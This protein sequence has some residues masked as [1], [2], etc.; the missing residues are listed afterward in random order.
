MVTYAM[1]LLAH[2]LLIGMLENNPT[3]Y[4]YHSS[5]TVVMFC[6]LT[7]NDA[8]LYADLLTDSAA[9]TIGYTSAS[10]LAS[11]FLAY[12]WIYFAMGHLMTTCIAVYYYVNCFGM[13]LHTLVPSFL[14][15]SFAC[16][17]IA[18]YTELLDKKE[19]LE[20]ERIK[21][22]K[23][24]LNKVLKSMPE[25]VMIFERYNIDKIKLWN[26]SFLNLFGNL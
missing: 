11:F 14:M 8:S 9:I 18:Y 26:D 5:L 17:S 13:M 15:S 2:Y 20:K 10:Y 21:T 6:T 12:Q 16:I 7:L 22:M 4:K 1:A 23:R 3:H 19:F 24:D 25:G